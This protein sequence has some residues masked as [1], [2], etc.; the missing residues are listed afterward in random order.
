M[1][2]WV[3]HFIDWAGYTGIFLL[4]LIET[5]FPPIPSEVIMPVAGARA[6]TGEM[7]LAG[8]AIAGTAGAMVGNLFW[9]AVAASLGEARFRL[10]VKRYGRWLTLDWYD[11]RRVQKAFGRWGGLLVLFGRLVPTVRSVIS[12]PAGLARMALLRFLIFS[13]FGTAMF[14]AALAAAGFVLGSSFQN[15]DQVL[16]PIS[17]GIFVLIVALYVWRQATWERRHRKR[18]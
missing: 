17:S 16:G 2:R 9:F 6:A 15:V 5:I 12:F 14:S 13:S 3:I 10:W 4:M 7:T 1:D 11:I 18:G 8:V